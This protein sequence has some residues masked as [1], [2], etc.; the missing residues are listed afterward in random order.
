MSG[1]TPKQEEE[2]KEEKK[3]DDGGTKKD[4]PPP[5]APPPKMSK[6]NEDFFTSVDQFIDSEIKRYTEKIEKK[7]EK[8]K[9]KNWDINENEG[10]FKDFS[11]RITELKKRKA[12]M[13]K[14]K[15]DVQGSA[16]P[17]ELLTLAN[18][19][20]NEAGSYGH[21]SKKA[22]AYAYLNRTGTPVR[23][24]QGA[25][26]S[27]YKKLK[28]RWDGLSPD[29]KYSFLREF[30]DSVK[31]AKERLE[32]AKPA[33]NDPTKGSTHWISPEA[34]IFDKKK[35]GNT[36]KRTIDGKVR[37]VPEWARS[38]SD[39]KV[40]KLQTGPKAILNS[41]FR[42]LNTIPHFLFYKGVKF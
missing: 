21:D 19:V 14:V 37:F 41:D 8:Y 29:E 13:A 2:K 35:G 27:D 22:V 42:E 40:K 15:T 39:P 30:P 28:D 25:E 23:E 20:Y 26:I 12:E 32:D 7:K 36:Q 11:D 16:S 24:P 5:E 18:V 3:A 6:E 9:A 10:E 17:D 38:N 1:C 4:E 31:A 33:T 34:K